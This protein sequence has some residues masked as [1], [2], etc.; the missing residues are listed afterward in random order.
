MADLYRRA[1]A[2]NKKKLKKEFIIKLNNLE[3]DYNKRINTIERL[4][5]IEIFFNGY[6]H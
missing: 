3:R 5:R 4:E 6:F 2:K 1:F